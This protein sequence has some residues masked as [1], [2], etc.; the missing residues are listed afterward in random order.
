MLK[1][2]LK[3]AYRNL[4]KH[5]LFSLINISGLAVGLSACLII[6]QCMSFESNFDRFHQDANGCGL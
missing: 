5:K 2:Y 1:N 3:I 4:L 6:L